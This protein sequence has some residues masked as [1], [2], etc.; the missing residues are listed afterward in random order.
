MTASAPGTRVTAN[1][2]EV[3]RI[4]VG[5]H[6]FFRAEAPA[7]IIA[8]APVLVMQFTSHFAA[9]RGSP[10]GDPAMMVLNP[11]ASFT[12]RFRWGTPALAPRHYPEDTLGLTTVPF[13]HYALITAPSN[14]T[15][16]VRLDGAPIPFGAISNDGSY[17]FGTVELQPGYHALDASDPVDVQLYGY[18]DYDAYATPAGMR[19]RDPFRGEAVIARTC[20]DQL[21]TTVMIENVGENPI[22]VTALTIVGDPGAAVLSPTLFPWT[23]ASRSR[24]AVRIRIRNTTVGTMYDTLVVQSATSGTRPVRIPIEVRHDSLSVVATDSLVVFA[25]ADAAFPYRDTTLSLVND[26]TA[27]ISIEQL[28]VSAPFSLI[29]PAPP[30]SIGV[31]D[32]VTIVLRFSPPRAGTFQGL[33]TITPGPCGAIRTVRLS[34]TRPM[35]AALSASTID[36]VEVR[37]ADPGFAEVPVTLR[38]LGG[39]DLFIDSIE[40]RAA[41]RADFSL[42]DAVPQILRTGDSAV[43]VRIRFAPRSIGVWPVS[44]R[45]WNNISPG[46]YA[47]LPLVAI[48][49]SSGITLI[50]SAIDFSVV[51]TC[52]STLVDSVAFRNSGTVPVLIDSIAMLHGST[53]SDSSPVLLQPGE[54]GSVAIAPAPAGGLLRDTLLLVTSPCGE[55]LRVPVSALRQSD[56]PELSTD[57]IDFG[58]G[59]ICDADRRSDLLLYNR[60]ALPIRVR[61][62]VVTGTPFHL[63]TSLDSE[64]VSGDSL[65][66]MIA[67]DPPA[68]GLFDGTLVVTFGPCGS[69]RSIPLVGRSDLPVLTMADTL[70]V[71]GGSAA[72]DSVL[73]FTIRNGSSIP[74]QIDSIAAA[75]TDVSIESA[76]PLPLRIDSG[77]EATLCLRYRRNGAAAGLHPVTLFGGPCALGH[78]LLVIDRGGENV[79][80]RLFLPDT[81]ASVDVLVDLPIRVESIPPLED[82]VD[83]RM[84]I[85]MRTNDV[86]SDGSDRERNDHG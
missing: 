59:A 40:I 77:K 63:V 4:G 52:D 29:T 6:S 32:T 41:D 46:G 71:D 17:R 20:S 68:E 86:D 15:A 19:L 38:N 54:I 75:S 35:A 2:T 12:T 37:C 33:L 5:E 49:D 1:G 22:E 30:F 58:T 79:G 36:S 69:T 60:G 53:L 55:R 62:A 70:F 47:L 57:S 67:F 45:V 23:V 14:S 31:G 72:L 39:E 51:S 21:D 56:L 48:R 26:G 50:D 80:L 44:I 7:T 24:L 18:S 34:G 61:S 73:C 10:G 76:T 28:D 9:P 84:R 82:S 3:A 64:I 27:A 25:N 65:R 11:V 78:R 16:S 74:E 85:L 83:L 81:S 66:L 42:I 43:V 13:V 8:S